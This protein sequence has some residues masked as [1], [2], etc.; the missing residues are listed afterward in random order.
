MITEQP[1]ALDNR[2]RAIVISMPN[3]IDRRLL[4]NKSLSDIPF[5][6]SFLDASNEH[7][8]S[9]LKNDINE[10]IRCF[11]RPLGAGEIGCFKSHIRAIAT[12]D[13]LDAPDWLLVLEDDVWL[14]PNFNFCEI[15]SR[16]DQDS[17]GF[18]RLYCRKWVPAD[19]VGWIGERQLLRFRTDPYGTQAYLI[20]KESSQRLRQNLSHILRP[21]DDQYGRF[22]EHGVQIYGIFPFPIVERSVSSTLLA[23]RQ[24]TAKRRHFLNYG[25]WITRA[26]DAT[27][28]RLYNIRHRHA[29]F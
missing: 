15:L 17:I 25:R 13:N 14:D 3:S 16:L 28:K 8:P 5:E 12:L 11:G 4:I 7:S 9:Q 18:A 24:G 2:L 27:R 29:K 23:D 21:I 26:K 22:W 20:N 19:I 6:W 1:F 10:Q